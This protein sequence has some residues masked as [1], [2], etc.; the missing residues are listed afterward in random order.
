MLGDVEV[1]SSS[2]RE[3]ELVL[4]GED[5]TIGN[6]LVK[7]LLLNEHV[8]T[9]YYRVEH[10]L[11]DYIVLYVLTDGEIKPLDAIVSAINS[12]KK[13]IGELS[14]IVEDVLGK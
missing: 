10:P 11:K 5:H 2:D 4:H 7:E 8:L 9:A 1:R 13:K 12:L 6:M 3:A 14:S